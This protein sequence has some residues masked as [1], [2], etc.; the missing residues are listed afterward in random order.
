MN[1]KIKIMSIYYCRNV[2]FV[3][4]VDHF[5]ENNIITKML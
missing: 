1:T 5:V 4:R 3:I 2:L